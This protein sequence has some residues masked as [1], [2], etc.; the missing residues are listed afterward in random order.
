MSSNKQAKSAILGKIRRSLSVS[1]QTEDEA[2]RQAAVKD[3]LTRRDRG[4]LPARSQV[5]H[6]GQIELFLEYALKSAAT[7]D[8][9]KD[10]DALPAAISAYLRHRNLPQKIRTGDDPRLQQADWASEP[11]LERQIGPSDGSDLVGVTHALGGVAETGT[12][13]FTSGPNNPNSLNFLPEDH[14]IV[15]HAHDIAGDYETVQDRLRDETG[16]AQMPRIV[17]RITGPSRSGDIEQTIL[18]GAHGPRA[19][20]VIVVGAPKAPQ[21]TA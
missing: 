20:H 9:V 14:I 1:S 5:D 13:I 19:V 11:Q 7:T 21:P 4:H 18:L 3:R 17:T 16:T 12:A 15:L 2:A 6:A 10:Y 8:Q